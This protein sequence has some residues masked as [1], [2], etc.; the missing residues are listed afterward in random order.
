MSSSAPL[1]LPAPRHPADDVPPTAGT[2]RTAFFAGAVAL[3]I[4]ARTCLREAE[5]AE[6]AQDRYAAAYLAAV[7]AAAAVLTAH[8]T[9]AANARPASVWR[10]LR[11]TAP[12]FGDWAQLFAAHSD[13]RVLAEAGV[14]V[15][16]GGDADELVARAGTFVDAVGRSLSWAAR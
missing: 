3:L 8:S 15:V 2:V 12:E 13:R 6:R 10:L 5:R 9:P 7:R 14:P 11:A 4:D 16:A 1:S